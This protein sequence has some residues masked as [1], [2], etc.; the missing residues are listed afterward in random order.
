MKVKG[1][2]LTEMALILPGLLMLFIVL[3]DLLPFAGNALIAM[4]E[5]SQGARAAALSSRPD[6]IT[7][8]FVR[9][10][11]VVETTS[12]YRSDVTWGAT[13]NCSSDPTIGIAQGEQVGVTI[14]MMYHSLWF[15][16]LQLTFSTEDYG[17]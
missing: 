12:F 10:A 17:R 1:Q 15:G 6:G 8:C 7:S 13:S 3:S 5:T 11:N 2:A 16:D 4:N 9:V 14:D